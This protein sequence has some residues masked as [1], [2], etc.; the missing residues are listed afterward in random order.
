MSE[1][2]EQ[3]KQELRSMAEAVCIRLKG[4]ATKLGLAEGAIEPSPD[5]ADYELSRDPAS[6]KD[7]LVCVWR[8]ARGNKQ[9]EMLFH[10]D[11]SFFAEYDVV[12]AH[13]Q[14]PK[15]FV[16]AVTAWGKGSDMKSEARLL[17]MME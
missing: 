10:A 11:G 17:P 8:D 3:R 12:Q 13:P 7:S 4:E 1:T 6:G 14:K 15:W 16:E 5:A 2:L 9:G